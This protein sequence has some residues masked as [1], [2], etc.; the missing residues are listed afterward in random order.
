MDQP[1]LERQIASS[2]R[3]NGFNRMSFKGSHEKTS[4]THT[5]QHNTS[6]EDHSSDILAR[7]HRLAGSCSLRRNLVCVG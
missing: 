2:C 1:P 7:I 6:M 4:N 5:T 3:L